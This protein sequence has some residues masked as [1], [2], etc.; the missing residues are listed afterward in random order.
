LPDHHFD[1][2]YLDTTHQF[3]DTRAE[4]QAL[5]PKVSE[6]GVIAGDDWHDDPRHV[7]HGVSRAVREFVSNRP[8]QLDEIDRFGQWRLRRNRPA[9]QPD[10]SR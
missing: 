5:E 10:S 7:N 9:N 2:A 4:L 3:E 1:W 6:S 8:W